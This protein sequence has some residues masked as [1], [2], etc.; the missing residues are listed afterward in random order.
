MCQVQGRRRKTSVSLTDPSPWPSLYGQCSPPPGSPT[1]QASCDHWEQAYEGRDSLLLCS[2]SQDGEM[3]TSCSIRPQ[4][5]HLSRPFGHTGPS[6]STPV[7][8]AQWPDTTDVQNTK[9]CSPGEMFDSGSRTLW[10][11]LMT[12]PLSHLKTILSYTHLKALGVMSSVANLSF[13]GSLNDLLMCLLN[14]HLL[15]T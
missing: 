1:G 8:P 14:Q 5:L 3:P 13:I 12:L 6:V 2:G 7:S 10:A 9:H 4:R 11:P 15:N